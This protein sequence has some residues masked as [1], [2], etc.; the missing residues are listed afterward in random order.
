M[1]NFTNQWFPVDDLPYA[2]IV[3][4]VHLMKSEWEPQVSLLNRDNYIYS[5]MTLWGWV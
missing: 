3:P 1:S 4:I 5:Q 2:E